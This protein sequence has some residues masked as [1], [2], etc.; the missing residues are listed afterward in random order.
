MQA[1]ILS[2]RHLV[3]RCP[4]CERPIWAKQ[5]VKLLGM[6]PF[7]KRFSEVAFVAETRGPGQGRGWKPV[8]ALR[9][10]Q[11]VSTEAGPEAVA[12]LKRVA[13]QGFQR[14]WLQGLI[15]EA[16]VASVTRIQSL[17]RAVGAPIPEIRPMAFRLEGSPVV[18]S[19]MPPA[20]TLPPIVPMQPSWKKGNR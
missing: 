9:T 13:L 14:A 8:G 5:L 10:L 11:E 1:N 4:T 6:I 16:D 15:S 18:A 20:R 3:A 12:Q 7:A 19:A 2:V 17:P